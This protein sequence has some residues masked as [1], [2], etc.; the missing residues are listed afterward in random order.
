[1]T[2]PNLNLENLSA[3]ASAIGWY[4]PVTT[5]EVL[6][7]KPLGGAEE[8]ITGI[9]LPFGFPNEKIEETYFPLPEAT[10]HGD[11]ASAR[12]LYDAVRL[13]FR[14]ASGPFRSIAKFNFAPRAYQMV[15]LIMALKQDDPVRLFIADDVGI[16]KTVESLMV[17]RELIDRGRI[18]RLA[19]VCPP[20]LCEQWQQEMAEKFGI[21][22]VIIRSSTAAT[23]DRKTPGD[24]SAFAY[25]PFQVVSIDYVKADKRRDSFISD[26]PELVIV[27]EVHT[28]SAGQGKGRQ[29]RNY[30]LQKLSEKSEQHLVLLSATPHSGKPEEFQSLLALLQPEFGRIE[31]NA[32][33]DKQ[34]RKLAQHY[35]QRRRADIIKWDGDKYQ[36]TTHF[37]EKTNIEVAYPMSP[38]YLELQF[39]VMQLAQVI[40]GKEEEKK[41]RKTLNYWTALGS[42]AGRN[43]LARRWHQHARKPGRPTN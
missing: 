29:Q 17:A 41:V 21:E 34:R 42:A 31:L 33:T 5:P 10:D 14:D 30:L 13:G 9:Y 38:E 27:D 8:E 16:G 37:P 24:T 7:I 36:E 28:A 18:K 2:P 3:C 6:R 11:L 32:S 4:N 12:L 39:D 1:L 35:V 15:P 43:E 25:Y 26:C 20:H 40:A 23:L 22:A 19:V